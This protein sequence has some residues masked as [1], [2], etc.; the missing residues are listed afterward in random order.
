[1]KPAYLAAAGLAG[2]VLLTRKPRI[3]SGSVRFVTAQR[4]PPWVKRKLVQLARD[5]RVPIEITSWTR[6]PEA[7]ARAM[8]AKVERG[9]DLYDLYR[10][11]LQIST[12]MSGP[13]TV[14]QWADTIDAFTRRGRPISR[15][16]AGNA[17]DVRIRTLNPVQIAKLIRTARKLDGNPVLESDHLHIGWRN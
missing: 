9:E 7:Q 14:E 17:T 12:L 4:G 10:D 16:L 3:R 13:R 15:H 8:L 6:S 2:F 11:D 5:S 1:M